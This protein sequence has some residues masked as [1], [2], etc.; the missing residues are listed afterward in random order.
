MY[1]LNISVTALQTHHM[2]EHKRP[3]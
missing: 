2:L 1:D 3:L